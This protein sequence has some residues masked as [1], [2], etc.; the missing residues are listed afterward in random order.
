MQIDTRDALD[1]LQ[2]AATENLDTGFLTRIQRLIEW[3][4]STDPNSMDRLTLIAFASTIGSTRILIDLK[5][6]LSRSAHMDPQFMVELTVAARDYQRKIDGREMSV[7]TT[8][9]AWW[10]PFLLHCDVDI[11]SFYE[12]RKLDNWLRWAYQNNVASPSIDDYLSYAKQWQTERVLHTLQ[13]IF[14]KLGVPRSQATEI[15]LGLAIKRKRSEHRGNG[16]PKPQPEPKLRY[17]I[18]P[19]ELPKH[20]HEVLENLK[21][22]IGQNGKRPPAK[23][24]IPK[25]EMAL[26]TFCYSCQK[27]GT[28]VELTEETIRIHISDLRA[29][30]WRNSSQQIEIQNLKRFMQ[31]LGRDPKEI[32]FVDSLESELKINATGEV[33]L[34]FQ[35]FVKIGSLTD[36]LNRALDLLEDSYAQSAL[37]KRVSKAAAGTALALECLLPLRSADTTLRWGEHVQHTGKRYRIEMQTSKT[38]NL[39]K[40]DLTEFLSPFFD[41]LLLQGCDVRLLP[42][43]RTK[44]IRDKSFLFCHADGRKI[45]SRRVAYIWDRH[46]GCGPTMARSLVHTELGKLGSTGVSQALAMC[47]QRSEQIQKFYQHSSMTDALLMKGNNA[48]LEGFSDEEI[49]ENFS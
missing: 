8:S 5:R 23:G 37:E 29:R 32:K 46:I 44:A 42:D 10:K 45:S 35:K 39:L 33:P 13:A 18:R 43:F 30:G 16:L 12:I 40:T 28:T 11:L 31:Y 48:L 4:K 34:K 1:S 41:A 22:G 27:S 21:Q 25:I 15:N 20:W 36:I 26:R 49:R 6:A 9:A 14:N 17:S 19:D 3:I 38:G 24:I 47:A 7:E 2:K